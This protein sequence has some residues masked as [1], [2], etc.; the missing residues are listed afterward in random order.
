LKKAG[1]A[2]KGLLGIN[3]SKDEEEEDRRL[4]CGDVV[5][6]MGISGMSS[7]SSLTPNEEPKSGTEKSNPEIGD[8]DSERF[9]FQK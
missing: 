9:H 1:A 5:D 6:S 4:V 3:R 8:D 7:S 2:A